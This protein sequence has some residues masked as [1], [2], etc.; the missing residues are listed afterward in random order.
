MTRSDLQPSE[1]NPYYQT[2]I[3]LVEDIPLVEA[4]ENGLEET[5]AFYRSL[6]EDKLEYR[7]APGKWTIKEIIQHLN[8]AERVFSYRAL[9]FARSTRADLPGFDQD[10]FVETSEANKRS[11]DEL[12]R[13]YEGIRLA[14]IALFSGFD[15]SQ[16]K[17]MGRASNSPFSARAAGY[18]NCGHEIHH[19]EIIKKRYLD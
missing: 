16:M 19:R 8:D 14:T 18:V 3:D 11:L 17:G 7:Y 2:Y 12:I 13:E 15:E 10:L 1:Y 4:L 6:P 5:L 9:W